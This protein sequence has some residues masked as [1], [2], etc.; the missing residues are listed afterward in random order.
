MQHAGRNFLFHLKDSSFSSFHLCSRPPLLIPRLLLAHGI[1]VRWFCHPTD[2][3][4]FLCQISKMVRPKLTLSYN[5]RHPSYVGLKIPLTTVTSLISPQWTQAFTLS[6][7]RQLDYH[8]PSAINP[9][10]KKHFHMFLMVKSPFSYGFPM[11][12]YHPKQVP[13]HKKNTVFSASAWSFFCFTR[14]TW[15]RLGRLIGFMA[16][17]RYS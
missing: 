4:S 9:I 12:F 3:H 10:K 7:V 14:R 5:V 16:R 15:M 8:P 2:P 13:D 17:K 11:V 1:L 6:Y